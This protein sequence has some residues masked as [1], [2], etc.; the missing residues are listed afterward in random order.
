MKE[1]NMARRYK[2]ETKINKISNGANGILLIDKPEGPTSFDVVDKIRSQFKLKKVG[3][4]G[5]LDPLA[6]GLL[7]ILIGKA[8]KLSNKLTSFDKKYKFSCLLGTS[9]NTDDLEGKILSKKKIDNID[10]EKLNAVLERY[11][12]GLKQKVPRFSAAKIN[13]KKLYELARA[14]KEFNLPQKGIFIHNLKLN[15]IELPEIM[16]SVHCSKGTYV[17][18]LCRDIGR[19]LG[20]GGCASR[21][22]RIS[23]GP[24]IVEDAVS[25]EILNNI[26]RRTLKTKIISLDDGNLQRYIQNTTT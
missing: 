8:T 19:D 11:Q 18:S 24:F 17:R 22:R 21:L 10:K 25:L 12:G 7:I 2:K 5:T 20:V 1:M 16:L 14:N 23:S 4:A 3:H 26:D 6:S 13:G 9:T 15:K